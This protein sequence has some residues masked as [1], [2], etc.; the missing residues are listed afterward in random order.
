MLAFKLLILFVVGV[1]SS[2]FFTAENAL[3]GSAN[4]QEP[5]HVESLNTSVKNTQ[6]PLT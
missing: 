2:L 3:A 5:S 4:S 6:G 1:L